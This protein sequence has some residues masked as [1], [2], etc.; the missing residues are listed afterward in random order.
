MDIKKIGKFLSERRK[1]L[2]LTQQEV[3]DRVGVSN[4]AISKWETGEGYP[5]ICSI[6]ELCRALG[7]SANDFFAGETVENSQN[8]NNYVALETS[9]STYNKYVKPYARHYLIGCCIFPVVII[10]LFILGGARGPNINGL[11]LFHAFLVLPVISII[12][13]VKF[14]RDQG[15]GIKLFEFSGFWALSS[16]AGSYITMLSL[17]INATDEIIFLIMLQMLGYAVITLSSAFLYAFIMKY[18]K[19]IVKLDIVKKSSIE[20]P[21]Q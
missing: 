12:L 14:V 3:A 11:F 2:G 19:Y 17:N 18:S 13:G 16:M 7:I 15:I 10:T 5:D 20:K 8:I 1:L 9:D 21:L 6:P 4:K